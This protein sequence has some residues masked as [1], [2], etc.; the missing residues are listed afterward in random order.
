MI[1]FLKY[2]YLQGSV[3]SLYLHDAVYMYALAT[4]E[5]FKEGGY[6]RN[7]SRI[8]EIAKNKTFQGK[9]QFILRK[10]TL[11]TN[12]SYAC[13]VNTVIRSIATLLS[14]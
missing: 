10:K 13:P 7:G 6:K 1:E 4:D 3:F 8:F 11:N 9:L 5:L 12:T 14:C 2:F